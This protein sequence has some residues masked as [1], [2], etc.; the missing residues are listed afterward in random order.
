MS[1]AKMFQYLASLGYVGSLADKLNAYYTDLIANGGDPDFTVAGEIVP[2]RS[3]WNAVN[4][5]ITAAN[6][7]VLSYWTA[8]RTETI[9]NVTFVSGSTA[10]GATPTLVR[11][12]V[13]AV[14]PNG[15]L[16]LIA[17]TPNDVNIFAATNT[18]YPK[19]LSVPWNKQVGQRYAV[20]TLVV[21]A[22]TV[23]TLSGCTGLTSMA[24]YMFQAPTL[25]SRL[26]G[27][28]DLPN[29]I[30]VGSLVANAF[31]PGFILS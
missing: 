12:G 22:T 1:T 19:A 16:T 31:R 24:P 23:P 10:A 3:T 4:V 6:S 29:F 20:G 13:Y 27:Q 21:T 9:N 5:P 28:T 18:A 26:A 14:A 25:C 2:D 17:S 8:R 11:Y 30:S 15:D 7:L